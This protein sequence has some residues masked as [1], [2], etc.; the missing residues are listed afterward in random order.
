MVDFSFLRNSKFLGLVE[1]ILFLLVLHAFCVLCFVLLRE[2]E[3]VRL[4]FEILDEVDIDDVVGV[5]H[6]VNIVQGLPSSLWQYEYSKDDS[7][8][9][10]DAKQVKCSRQ[11]H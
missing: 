5:E 8:K 4:V 3:K 2:T 10:H 9:S 11:G 1:I 6:L 7:K